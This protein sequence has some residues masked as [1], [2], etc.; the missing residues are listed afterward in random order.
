MTQTFTLQFVHRLNEDGTIDSICR[1][2]FVTVATERSH[3]VIERE[4]RRH[5]CHPLLLE[6]YKKHQHY[7]DFS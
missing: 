4:E 7:E 5:I 2:C 1:N 6:R 3:S